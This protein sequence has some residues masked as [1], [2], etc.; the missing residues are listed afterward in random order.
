MFEFLL[1]VRC[2][3]IHS[4]LFLYFEC[5]VSVFDLNGANSVWKQHEVNFKSFGP[6]CTF[7]VFFYVEELILIY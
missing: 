6:S 2:F 5:Y 1:Y 4:Y 3:Y 7:D